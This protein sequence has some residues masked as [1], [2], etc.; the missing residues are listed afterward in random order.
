MQKNNDV[1]GLGNAIM[2]FLVEVEDSILAELNL[3]KGEMTLV[4]E[5][6][7]QEI[8]SLFNKKNLKVEQA[9]GGSCANAIRGI[10]FL[11][12][13][14]ILS[15]KVGNDAHG[16]C[17][18]D[19]IQKSG[20]V[21]KIGKHSKK[22][23]GQALAFITPD[24]QRTFSVHL[25]AAIEFYKDDFLEEDIQQSKVLH[26]EGYQ[27]EGVAAEAVLQAMELARKHGTKVSLDLA[28]P[29][30]VRRNKQFLQRVVQDYVDILFANE[31]EVREFTTEGDALQEL[32]KYGT[33]CVVKLGVKG[34][35][36][37]Q[38]GKR[39]TIPSFPAKAI[40]TTGAGD[41]YA[42][43]FL[44]GYCHD[45]SMEEAGKLGSLFASKMVEQ[46]GVRMEGLDAKEMKGRV[47]N[48]R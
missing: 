34:S 45:W 39:T 47:K 42:A 20:V 38:E 13:K 48:E 28:D 19:E 24:A 27:L 25:G 43:G 33:L 46:K 16:Q 2:D 23:T 40:D 29:G 9:P 12:G 36:I 15:A 32:E 10:A 1:L 7:A 26:L 3:K 30:I 4:E 35:I 14:S 11:G 21:S 6:K 18:I 44:Y 8:F 5:E 41:S 17:Y 37:L 22:K 31:E